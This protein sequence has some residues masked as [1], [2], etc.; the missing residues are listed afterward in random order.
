MESTFDD[1]IVGGVKEKAGWRGLGYYFF[2]K[3]RPIGLLLPK[4]KPPRLSKFR[5]KSVLFVFGAELEK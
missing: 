5:E 3:D 1:W 2:A 4:P